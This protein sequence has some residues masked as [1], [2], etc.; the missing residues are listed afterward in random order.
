MSVFR[1]ISH[2]GSDEAKIKN[3]G[4]LFTR[5]NKKTV[6]SFRHLIVR[7]TVESHV[8]YI[9]ISARRDCRVKRVFS[10]FK[11]FSKLVKKMKSTWETFLS[12]I[13]VYGDP[14]VSCT[15]RYYYDHGL[16]VII[17]GMRIV[18]KIFVGTQRGGR[19]VL[20]ARDGDGRAGRRSVECARWRKEAREMCRR[21]AR[22]SHVF[23]RPDALSSDAGGRFADS[24]VASNRRGIRVEKKKN[25]IPRPTD[26]YYD[27]RTVSSE[28]PWNAC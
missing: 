5:K 11:Y 20:S 4:K 9:F 12:T 27:F 10:P 19:R 13:N 24:P 7:V 17:I 25:T 23:Y 3:Q 1:H 22:G 6:S 14:L 28:D 26:I 18:H 2:V 16:I 15:R 8:G 21:C